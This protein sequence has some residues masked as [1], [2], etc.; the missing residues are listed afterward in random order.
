MS[1]SHTYNIFYKRLLNE[2]ISN[3]HKLV[4]TLAFNL[5]FLKNDVKRVLYIIDFVHITTVFLTSNKNILKVWRAQVRKLANYVLMNSYYKSI[6]LHEPEK[7]SFNFSQH[8]LKELE[9]CLLSRYLNFALPR[10]NLYYADYILPFELLF[11]DV[12]LYEIPS[13]NK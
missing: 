2:E 10:K 1:S 7:D 12:G 4:L 13:L 8:S 5:T 9:K 6:T 3:K 11:R